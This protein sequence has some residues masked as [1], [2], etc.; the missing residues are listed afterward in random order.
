MMLPTLFIFV[1]FL[2][3]SAS[4][5]YA[6]AIIIKLGLKDQASVK[7]DYALEPTVAVLL[8]C[9]NE[10]P[11]VYRTI[12][13][14]VASDYPQGKL[15]VICR[16]DASAD[17]SYAWML[18]AQRD[19]P[20]VV[21]ARNE[22]N[23]GKS[24][25][26]CL[27][28]AESAAEIVIQIDSDCYFFPNAIREMVA[29]F[30]DPNI[31]GVGGAVGVRNVN[32]N[33]LTVAQT[34]AY[35]TQFHI[36]VWLYNWARANCCISGCMLAIRRSLLMEISPL[37]ESRN[38]FGTPLSEGEDRYLT[39]EI[40]LR[41]YGT[42]INP[43]AQCLTDVPNTLSKLYNQQLR[44]R[45]GTFRDFFWTVRHLPENVAKLNVVALYGEII[46]PLGIIMSGLAILFIP[47][48]SYTASLLPIYLLCQSAF[49]AVV[50]L[51]IQKTNPEQTIKHPWMI[52]GFTLWTVV[53]CL[54]TILSLGTFDSGDWGTRTALATQLMNE[55][56]TEVQRVY[57]YT[58]TPKDT[59]AEDQEVIAC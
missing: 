2:L 20:N 1:L 45:R 14:I 13:S 21:A 24:R 32:D 50:H 16:D 30:A 7:K 59:Q 23:L 38:W 11:A 27:A 15:T 56:E 19:F 42:Y 41:G 47:F 18:K 22:S 33:A 58:E 29:C 37:I 26:I 12:E 44:W 46:I 5:Q 10:G 34:F 49:A 3:M 4:L 40:L 57:A 9:Y 35:Y 6:L 53:S 31:G 48:I 28:A 54:L 8:S 25:T 43:E 39:H 36:V 52:G 51:L 55:P 17:D